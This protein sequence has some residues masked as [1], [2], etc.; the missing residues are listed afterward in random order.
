MQ[1]TEQNKNKNRKTID[2]LFEPQANLVL[3]LTTDINVKKQNYKD[4]WKKHT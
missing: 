4:S 3:R 1:K 2:A